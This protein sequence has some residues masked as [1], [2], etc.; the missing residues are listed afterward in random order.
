MTSLLLPPE[1]GSML[2]NI[3]NNQEMQNTDMAGVQSES[4]SKDFQALRKP[5]TTCHQGDT[6]D[7]EDQ[8][9]HYQGNSVGMMKTIVTKSLVHQ[10]T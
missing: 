1:V 3:Q 5:I 2:K 6:T 4:S 7:N 10:S 8:R 9:D